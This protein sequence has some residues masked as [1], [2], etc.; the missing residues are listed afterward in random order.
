[1]FLKEFTTHNGTRFAKLNRALSENYDYAVNFR[2]MTTT[3]AKKMI[4]IAEQKI[5]ES[6]DTNQRVKL[7]LIAESL[8]LW[9]QAAVQSE[10]TAMVAEGFDDAEM[11]GAKV[12]L[13]AKELSDKIQ[14]MI[15]DGAKMQV[16]DLLPIVDAMKSEVGPEEAAAFSATADAALGG[17]VEA[18]KGTKEEYDNAISA[19]QGQQVDTD[20]DG[21][22][23]DELGGD[24]MSGDMDIDMSAM[25]DDE[26]LGDIDDEFGGDD[27]DMGGTEPSGREMKA[28][29]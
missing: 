13:A 4:A 7:K 14:S 19:A 26:G 28:E 12:I 11:E 16:Q 18:L 25:G 21:F 3:K 1:M 29:I 27:G 8:T 24:D 5:T 9:H 17:L 2:K 15:E 6:N 20:M 22:G 10:L 23:G